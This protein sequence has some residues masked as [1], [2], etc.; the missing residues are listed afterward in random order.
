M[1]SLQD[2]VL[3]MRTYPGDLPR[4]E[5]ISGFQPTYFSNALKGAT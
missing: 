2:E 3:P 1:L 4:A 5:V